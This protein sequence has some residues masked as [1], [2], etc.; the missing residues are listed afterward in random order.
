MKRHWTPKEIEADWLLLLDERTLL[1]N[2]TGATRFG[3]AELLKFFQLEG[4]FPSNSKEV[5]SEVVACVAQQVEVAPGS[6]AE[7]HWAG[8]S[9]KYHRTKI[10]AFTGF[11]EATLA[12]GRDLEAWLVKEGLDQEQRPDQIRD[13][14][15]E[16]ALGRFRSLRIEPPGP[17]RL[18][19]IINDAVNRHEAEFTRSVFKGL[20]R[21]TIE[22]M[23]ALL[24]HQP[25]E[26]G[27]QRGAERRG[28]VERHDRFHFL[29]QGR[30]PDHEPPGKAGNGP[31]LPPPVPVQPRLHQH[32][33]DPTC[34]QGAC[35]GR[36]DDGT[37]PG[38]AEPIAYAAHQS[39]WTLRSGS[40]NP[41]PLWRRH[42]PG[43][44][45]LLCTW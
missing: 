11:R 24:Q 39:N 2:K 8:R 10:R 18:K 31:P 38:R 20:S 44:I 27:D 45:P 34:P 23:D 26:E 4:R 15:L 29:R 16:A 21:Q 13:A 41:D 3:F 25:A 5:P 7:Y 33:D 17:E 43:L 14:G 30:R 40:G 32:L 22:N 12:D 1:A 35:V 19:R 42:N 36:A 37:G 28:V 9:I 6:W